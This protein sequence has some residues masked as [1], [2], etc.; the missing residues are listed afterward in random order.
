MPHACPIKW[1]CAPFVRAHLA[2]AH[3]LVHK[4]PHHPP[5]DDVPAN[6]ECRAHRIACSRGSASGDA[7]VLPSQP[8]A[9]TTAVRHLPNVVG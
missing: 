5:R 4:V 2:L 1:R 9:T 6:G 8:P 3:V 7:V